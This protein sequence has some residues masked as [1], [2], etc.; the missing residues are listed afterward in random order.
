MQPPFT[1]D[2]RKRDSFLSYF[3]TLPPEYQE[4]GHPSWPQGH[5]TRNLRA[6]PLR[7]AAAFSAQ[8][9]LTA[10]MASLEYIPM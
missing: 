8:M 9:M 1:K 3:A 5:T 6:L 7:A 10:L 4:K 2:P